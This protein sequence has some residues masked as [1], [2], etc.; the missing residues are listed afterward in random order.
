[1]Y[2]P[3]A[4]TAAPVSVWRSAASWSKP[5]VAASR[6]SAKKA[7]APPSVLTYC[8]CQAS[9]RR[10][11]S[12]A[13]LQPHSRRLRVLCAEDVAV[14]QLIVRTQLMHMGHDVDMVETS[15][16]AV[17]ALASDD[18]DVVLMDGRMPEMDSADATRAI[19]AGG[20]P[21]ARVRNPHIRIIALTAN[22]SDE[23]RQQYL[24]AGMDDFVTKPVSERQ[25]HRVL[26]TV[27]RLL[28]AEPAP[29]VETEHTTK[30]QTTTVPLARPVADD[31]MERVMN[32][33]V[34]GVPERIT[35]LDAAWQSRDLATLAHLFHGIGRSAN[36]IGMDE[37]HDFA[38][39]LELAATRADTLLL[40]R[41]Y[42]RLRAALI[43]I[44]ECFTN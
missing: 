44:Q 24:G 9:H 25:L 7:S 42:P 26:E 39:Q 13:P 27:I 23:D 33:F 34:S 40:E 28:D 35:L 4:A 38:T 3:R 1:M 6:W 17:Q 15:I 12:T 36:T 41:E 8:L 43:S 14:D 11:K 19:R 16:A 32:V 10:W 20:L 18:Y 31:L 2:P 5:W 29:Q 30:N 37:M 21:Y 22:A